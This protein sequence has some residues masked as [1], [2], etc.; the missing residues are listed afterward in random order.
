M[1][2]LI[3][4]KDIFSS[5]YGENA[6]KVFLTMKTFNIDAQDKYPVFSFCFKGD[7]F[8]WYNNKSIQQS[9][10]LNVTQFVQLLK[11]QIPIGNEKN[12]SFEFTEKITAFKNND[13]IKQFD[14]FHVK[15][16]DFLV[17]IQF[18]YERAKQNLNYISNRYSP[19]TPNHLIYLSYQSP[20]VI[21]FTRNES[22]S[23]KSIRD[24]DLITLN[25]SIF[26]DKIFRNM[27]LQIFIKTKLRCF[28]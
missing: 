4:T 19:S 1:Y 20:D 10:R 12:N 18:S 17:E 25:S 11:G 28:E 6:D 23:S 9:Y 13:S 15:Q 2:K 26:K 8:H 3:K 21:C 24:Y 22:E 27:T 7:S 14:L 5:H 16:T